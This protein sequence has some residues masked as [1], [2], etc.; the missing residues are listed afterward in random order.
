MH[1]LLDCYCINMLKKEI[2]VDLFKTKDSKEAAVVESE[3][4][5]TLFLAVV[6]IWAM[7]DTDASFDF[8]IQRTFWA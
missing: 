3:E 5:H 6:V 2:A 1:T 7:L 8:R 4:H